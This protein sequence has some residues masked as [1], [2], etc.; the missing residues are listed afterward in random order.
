MVAACNPQLLYSRVLLSIS[1]V[2]L[3]KQD[4]TGRA[5]LKSCTVRRSAG[6][7]KRGSR[8][9]RLFAI[10]VMNT[11][12]ESSRWIAAGSNGM[13]GENEQ[14]ATLKIVSSSLS[15]L[16]P[17]LGFWY[18]TNWKQFFFR[19][20]LTSLLFSSS[21]FFFPSFLTSSY[22]CIFRLVPWLC[23]P[24]DPGWGNKSLV[25]KPLINHGTEHNRTWLEKKREEDILFYIYYQFFFNTRI[26]PLDWCLIY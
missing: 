5:R 8:F 21:F 17:T 4:K 7:R 10:V 3:G 12:R 1:I 9:A 16:R 22:F 15:L 14:P 20:P 26:M 24:I 11:R 13:K 25:W 18:Q 23:A 2:P 19:L 6:R